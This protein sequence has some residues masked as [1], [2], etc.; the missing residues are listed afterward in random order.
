M[1]MGRGR[2]AVVT[3]ATSGIGFETAR[4]LL[5]RGWHV[6]GVGRSPQ[7]IA[8]A[9]CALE[10]RGLTAPAYLE[11]DLSSLRS[12]EDLAE[13]IG[14]MADSEY[15]GAI[16][17]LVSV[18]GAVSSR[19]LTTNDG[20]EF[21]MAVNHYA[22]FLLMRRLLPRLLAAGESAYLTVTSGTHRGAR[23]HWEDLSLRRRYSIIGAY[24]QSKLANLLVTYE[25]S[26]RLEPASGLRCIAFDPGLVNTAIG[27]KGTSSLARLAWRL[28]RHGGRSPAEAAW[29]L[30][31]HLGPGQQSSSDTLYRGIDRDA[32]P[33]DNALS[34]ADAARVWALSER[35]CGLERAPAQVPVSPQARA[36]GQTETETPQRSKRVLEAR[37]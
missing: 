20:L 15:G 37:E 5:G 36:Q 35:V 31:R 17:A 23:M 12:A 19:H 11:A 24:G 33:G 3:G 13:E 27:E 29:A 7:R 32:V 30:V 4:L 9:Q 28:R 26:R 22:P 25:L 34:H 18:A 6:I 21:Q 16:E 8:Q 14:R 2:T 1:H 10:A